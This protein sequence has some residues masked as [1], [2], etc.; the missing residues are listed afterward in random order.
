M[1]PKLLLTLSGIFMGLVGLGFLIS[2]VTMLGGIIDASLSSEFRG[3]SSTFLGIAVLNL[4]AR[5][6][7]ASK[8]REAI[9]IGN[10]VGFGLAA[11]L[12]GARAVS[13][14]PAQLWVVS[15][16]NLLFAIGFF[17]VGRANMSS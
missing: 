3:I 14:G 13:G 1:K 8:T 5:N 7:E 4:V 12:D 2:P 16:I 6:A 17:L 9:L 11:V 10:T 15:I